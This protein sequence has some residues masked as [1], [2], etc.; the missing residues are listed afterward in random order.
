MPSRK[1]GKRGPALA[2][3]FGIRRSVQL[4]PSLLLCPHL[5]NVEM[6]PFC[7]RGWGA[8]CS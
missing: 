2:R 8:W 4:R 3:L 6:L 1:E 5:C 7:S